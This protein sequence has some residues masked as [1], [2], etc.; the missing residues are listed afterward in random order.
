MPEHLPW[1]VPGFSSSESLVF[2][3]QGSSY[4]LTPH[5]PA[6]LCYP[7]YLVLSISVSHSSRIS[8]CA[9]AAICEPLI[10]LVPTLATVTGYC[11]GV[12][13]LQVY[14]CDPMFG[15]REMPLFLLLNLW[16]CLFVRHMYFTFIRDQG[17]FI[18]IYWRLPLGYPYIDVCRSSLLC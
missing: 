18:T 6:H 17:P 9:G 5:N 12:T 16:K 14:M 1:V 13:F 2:C 11:P 15:W 3:Q 7:L 8:T 10:T 4:W